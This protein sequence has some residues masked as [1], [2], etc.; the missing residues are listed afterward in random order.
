[1]LWMRD[2]CRDLAD[3]PAGFREIHRPP[4]QVPE[5]PID[6]G[7][8]DCEPMKPMRFARFEGDHFVPFGELQSSEKAN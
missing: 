4:M 8:T 6:S 1:M 5:L 2:I 7:P 3:G